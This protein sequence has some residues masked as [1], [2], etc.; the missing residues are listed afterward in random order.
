MIGLLPLAFVA[1][2]LTVAAP[3]IVPVL[4]GILSGSLG[5]N[6]WRPLAIVLGLVASFT[7]F[8]T[9]FA[10]VLD[11][12]GLSKETVRTLS[13]AIL[14]IL[15][16]ALAMPALWEWIFVKWTFVWRKIKAGANYESASNL[17]ISNSE[18]RKFGS[19][20]QLAP[21]R[22]GFWSAFGI[23]ASLGAIWTPCA[24]PILGVILTFAANS[25]DILQSGLL[26]FTYALGAGFPMLII[27]YGTRVLF[28]KI[29]ALARHEMRVRKIAG[30]LLIGWSIALIFNLD[31]T[32][33]A[34]LTQFVP[35]PAL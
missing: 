15:G 28:L 30:V 25:H 19:H 14:F 21:M 26:V 8:G 31:Q 24:G 1:G 7:I 33:Q 27:G 12:V 11:F 23:G 29:K 4:P 13:I 9:A 34:F 6:K 16:M 35:T 3:C 32:L 10:I 22:D 20:S 17:R 2:V 18:I 5:R